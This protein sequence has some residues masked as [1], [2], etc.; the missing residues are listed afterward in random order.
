MGNEEKL[1]WVCVCV[2]VYI[3]PRHESSDTPSLPP[4]LPASLS[5]TLSLYTYIRIYI[6]MYLRHESSDALAIV[7]PKLFF[8]DTE[9]RL[10]THARMLFSSLKK[11]QKRMLQRPQARLLDEVL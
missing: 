11:R 4:S 3:Q 1:M 8:L 6:Y 7:H 9:C 5:L 10:G 2:C